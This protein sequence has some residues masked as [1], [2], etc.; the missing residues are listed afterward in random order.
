[1]SNS[2]KCRAARKKFGGADTSPSLLKNKTVTKI[3]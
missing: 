1:L 3:Q 2:S